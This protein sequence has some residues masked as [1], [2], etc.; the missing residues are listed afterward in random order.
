MSCISSGQYAANMGEQYGLSI[1]NF[2]LGGLPGSL[3]STFG[4]KTPLDKLKDKLNDINDKTHKIMQN[5]NIAL[6]KA[7]IKINSEL[8]TAITKGNADLIETLTYVREGLNE[9]ITTNQIYIAFCYISI[10][11][12]YIYLMSN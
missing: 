11:I 6:F 3:M 9:K 8:F 12:L 5:G 10:I 7:Q 2:L 1:G 4:G